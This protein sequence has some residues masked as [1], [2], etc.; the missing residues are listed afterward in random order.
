MPTRLVSVVVRDC[1][2]KTA[3]KNLFRIILK[4]N[5]LVGVVVRDIEPE[6]AGADPE[7]NVRDASLPHQQLANMFLM[8][9]VF[10]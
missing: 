9:T 7:G 10:P 8:N 3:V 4:P 6:R 2:F 1:H 5:R